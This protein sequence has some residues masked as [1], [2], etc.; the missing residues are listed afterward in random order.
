MSFMDVDED[1]KE[2]QKTKA[3]LDREEHDLNIDRMG[4]RSAAEKLIAS[5]ALR[6][7]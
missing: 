5:S 6:R 2:K 7:Q 4:C 1:G 3:E